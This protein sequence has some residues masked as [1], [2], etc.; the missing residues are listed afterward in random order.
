MDSNIELEKINS[1][2]LG[3]VL[4]YLS[5]GYKTK[6][7]ILKKIDTY[8]NKPYISLND[9]PF[10]KNRVVERLLELDL[11]DDDRVLNDILSSIKNSTKAKNKHKITNFLMKKGFDYTQI[12]RLFDNLD[13]N[14]DLECARSDYHKILKKT[15]DPNKI[16]KYLLNKGYTFDV[17]SSLISQS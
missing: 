16:K 1:L 3:K 13:P 9:K 12:G 17:I 14:Y 5:Y 2:V 7:E 8:L 15:D 11:I 6:K 4:N 10:I